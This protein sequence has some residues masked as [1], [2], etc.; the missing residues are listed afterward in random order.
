MRS[1]PSGGLPSGAPAGWS[2]AKALI[3]ISCAYWL[4][5]LLLPP[6]QDVALNDDWAYA[7]IVRCFLQGGGI[8]SHAITEPTG[9]V[10]AAWGMIFTR[11]LGPGHGA[12]RL[13][14]L[15][16]GWVGA[17]AFCDLLRQERRESL[18]CQ[19]VVIGLLFAFNP[20]FFVLCPSF[21]TDVPALALSLATLAVSRR[22]FAG[23]LPAM[24]GLLLGSACA[25]LAYGI[26][27]T[28]ILVP[29]GLTACYWRECRRTP[30]I[31]L[32]IW[33]LPC[34]A[35]G[36]HQFWLHSTDGPS[37]GIHRWIWEGQAGW[38]GSWMLAVQRAAAAAVYCGLFSIPLAAAFCFC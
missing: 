13:S 26:R 33:S 29:I 32:A 38:A 3:L 11:L 24:R 4:A 22:A 27:Q 8:A 18:E 6:F 28:A 23:E 35:A 5:V 2:F 25:A 10:Q 17:M 20:L 37:L 14:T 30:R 12:L 9:I 19:D 15:V 36:G 21:M 31:L 16:L 7:F 34:A 1:T